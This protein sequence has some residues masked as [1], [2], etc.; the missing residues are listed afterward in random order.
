MLGTYVRRRAIAAGSQPPV[1]DRQEATGKKVGHEAD[2]LC[3]HRSAGE[4]LSPRSHEMALETLAY[5]T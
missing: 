3:P 1:H 2:A 5:L 4:M